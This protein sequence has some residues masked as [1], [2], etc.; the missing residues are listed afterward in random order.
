MK[1]PLEELLSIVE[2][3]KSK[4]QEIDTNG[5]EDWLNSV[6][7][8]K[9]KEQR[10]KLIKEVCI[11]A[12]FKGSEMVCRNVSIPVFEEDEKALRLDA[13]DYYNEVIKPKQR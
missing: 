5:L 11:E 8:P 3:L 13:E 12:H 2:E 7:I 6:G 1:T 9:E 4:N 10:E